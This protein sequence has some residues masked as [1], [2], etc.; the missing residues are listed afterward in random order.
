MLKLTFFF[1]LLIL[2]LAYCVGSYKPAAAPKS[3]KPAAAPKSYKPAAA[4]KS[5]N[6]V[7]D[8]Q[9]REDT[10]S[11]ALDFLVYNLKIAEGERKVTEESIE[12]LSINMSTFS[13]TLMRL[14]ELGYQREFDRVTS[15]ANSQDIMNRLNAVKRRYLNGN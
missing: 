8:R 6:V 15:K 2:T 11:D 13:G 5:S 14:K 4:P 1:L 3:S 7:S 10:A 12:A 9:Y